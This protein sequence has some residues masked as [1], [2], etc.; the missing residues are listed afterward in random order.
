MYSYVQLFTGCQLFALLGYNTDACYH[1]LNRSHVCF[2][3]SPY[4]YSFCWECLRPFPPNMVLSPYFKTWLNI[5][6]CDTLSASQ[7]EWIPWCA[8]DTPTQGGN[9]SPVGEGRNH[10]IVHLV[11]GPSA[12]TAWVSDRW[13][14]EHSQG[15]SVTPRKP[16]SPEP[17]NCAGSEMAQSWCPPGLTSSHVKCSGK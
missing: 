14:S 16:Q 17:P 11:Q 12:L 10:L 1:F 3:R 13:C 15:F 6:L 4:Y 2:L 5:P 8:S 7:V 9:D